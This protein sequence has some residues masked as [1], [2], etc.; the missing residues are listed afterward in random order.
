MRNLVRYRFRVITGALWATILFA[1]P[2]LATAQAARG[3]VNSD[4]DAES[5]ARLEPGSPHLINPEE[6]AKVIRSA[7]GE[8]PLILNVGPYLL[9]MQAHIPGAEYIGPSSDSQRMEALLKRVKS[10]PRDKFIVLYCGCCPW[11]HC[12]NVRAAYYELHK[13][14]FTKAKVL[15]IANN[16]GVDWVYKGYPAIKGQ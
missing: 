14:G 2:S 5:A 15:Y 3:G 13:A 6:M 9:Y 10:L 12:P 16:L 4:S 7:K 8:K 11:S 1:N